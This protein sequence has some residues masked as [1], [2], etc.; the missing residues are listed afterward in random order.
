[1]SGPLKIN[2]F[3]LRTI[4]SLNVSKENKLFHCIPGP[5]GNKAPSN[6]PFTFLL[7][8]L[9]VCYCQGLPWAMGHFRASRNSEDVLRGPFW[10]PVGS[11]G[12]GASF[13]ALVG[14]SHRT[15]LPVTNP[16]SCR[17]SSV[18]YTCIVRNR[19]GSRPSIPENQQEI[20]VPCRKK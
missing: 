14:G 16:P 1:M 7:K 9:F 15:T 5:A 11:L 20:S 4:L 18:N 12:P 10:T 13:V 8:I 3:C 2:V 19:K 17:R 6:F